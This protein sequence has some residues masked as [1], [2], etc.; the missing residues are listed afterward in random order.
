MAHQV[1]GKHQAPAVGESH[2]GTLERLGKVAIGDKNIYEPE[3]S[4]A[5]DDDIVLGVCAQRVEDPGFR[6]AISRVGV[7][8][9]DGENEPEAS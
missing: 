7:L 6:F 2:N 1:D 9:E 8:G 4:G 3:G 5:E